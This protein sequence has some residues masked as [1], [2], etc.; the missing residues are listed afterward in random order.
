MPLLNM[1]KRALILNQHSRPM[2]NRARIVLL[3][4]LFPMHT[5]TMF[6]HDI[7]LSIVKHLTEFLELVFRLIRLFSTVLFLPHALERFEIGAI[8][9]EAC[10]VDLRAD[11]VPECTAGIEEGCAHEEVHEWGAVA[12]TVWLLATRSWWTKGC[13]LV[14]EYFTVFLACSDHFP[15]ASYTALIRLWAL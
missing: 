9:D 2:L 15:E 1:I 14:Q 6:T 10:H 12:A 4:N 13:V 5:P 3:I 11:E 7:Q 8:L